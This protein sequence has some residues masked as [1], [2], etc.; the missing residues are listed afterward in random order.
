MN[1][2]AGTM[3]EQMIVAKGGC[4]CIS[5]GIGNS[6]Q[7]GVRVTDFLLQ[8]VTIVMSFSIILMFCTTQ[9]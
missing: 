8:K 3:L 7:W 4:V 5:S 2:V 6:V 1:N 9:T